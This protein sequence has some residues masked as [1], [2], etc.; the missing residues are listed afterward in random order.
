MINALLEEYLRHYMIV[1]QRN[2]L[3]LFDNAQFNYNLHK[4]ST[5][6]LSPFELKLTTQI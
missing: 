6:D 4:S 1:T 5:M 3:E 2:W